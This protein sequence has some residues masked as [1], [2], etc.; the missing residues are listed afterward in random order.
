MQPPSNT[1]SFGS[2]TGGMTPE[3]QEAI[4]RRQGGNPSGAMAQVSNSAPT[5]NP[6]TQVR[7]MGSPQPVGTPQTNSLPTGGG[8]PTS[9][10]RII[11]QALK[12]R[13]D[14]LSKGGVLT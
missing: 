3:L 2:A 11:L 14:A 7:S 13:L 8:Q 12:G 9:E 6:E 5:A 10:A 4:T 1:G